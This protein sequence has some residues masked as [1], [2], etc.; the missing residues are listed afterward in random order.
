MHWPRFTVGLVGLLALS[1]VAL[2][3]AQATDALD[4]LRRQL[5]QRYGEGKY[6]EALPI[7]EQYLALMRQKHGEE[8]L[9]FAGAMG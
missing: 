8:H 1:G 3:Q 6:A 4:E 2:V 9:D 5:S 7:A